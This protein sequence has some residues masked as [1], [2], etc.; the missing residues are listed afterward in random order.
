VTP[1]DP[2]GL[3]II[4]GILKI[5]NMMSPWP[6]SYS[7]SRRHARRRVAVC[8]DFIQ[9]I[10]IDVVHEEEV[11][12][13][14]S[15]MQWVYSCF[16]IRDDIGLLLPF[17]FGEHRLLFI[18][19]GDNCLFNVMWHRVSPSTGAG[20]RRV[21]SEQMHR[22]MK[23]KPQFNRGEVNKNRALLCSSTANS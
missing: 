5:I 3:F 7:T 2:R 6:A 9:S 15:E 12:E 23:G 1:H 20:Q 18:L 16:H 21:C 17:S 14:D 10:K 11:S 13:N 19:R 4:R 8:T 22:G